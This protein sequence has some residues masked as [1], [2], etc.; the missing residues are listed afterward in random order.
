MIS[1][2]RQLDKVPRL[3]LVT[4]PAPLFVAPRLSSSLG[5]PQIW[6]KR[7]DLLPVAFG[8]NKVRSLDL[9]VAD[10]MRRGADT[11]VTGAGPLSNH[12]RASAG[13]AAIAGL[14]CR[15]VYWG[16]RPA[17][18]EGNHLLS[19]LLGAQIFFTNNPERTSADHGIATAAA[20]VA[21]CGGRPYV[22]PR[23]GAC[24]LAVI[25]HVLAVR[26]TLDQCA[27]LGV[28]PD[29]VV[30]AV[31]GGATLGGWLLGSAA[32]EAKWRIDAFAVSRS[33]AEASNL[34]RGLAVAAA[35]EID[36]PLAFDGVECLV[37]DGVLGGGYGIPSSEGQAAIAIVAR[38]EGV[39]LDPTYTGKAMAGYF[40]L[41]AKGRYADAK[42]VL[43]LHTGGTPSLFT[44][45][46]EALS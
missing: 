32:F 24:P 19:K 42:A 44:E 39:F 21:R 20:E 38:T 40:D 45:A 18:L 12:V 46:I 16:N 10:A 1:W 17:R 43:F 26:E 6:L 5:G 7:D 35:A 13:V 3:G 23:G 33:A 28:A 34:A 31:G 41:L 9:I 29:V 11:L 8:G 2:A 37:H 25:A 22:I 4:A 30:M 15:A 27:A 36:C 14:G